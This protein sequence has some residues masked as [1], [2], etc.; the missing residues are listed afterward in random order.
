MRRS[1]CEDVDRQQLRLDG[2]VEI[3][4]PS[5]NTDVLPLQ[6]LTKLADGLEQIEDLW[7]DDVSEGEEGSDIDVD[8]DV[9]VWEMDGEGQ[10]VGVE[11]EE[12]NG[13]WS[14]DEGEDEAGMD[15]D[16]EDGWSSSDPTIHHSQDHELPLA[17]PSDVAPASPVKKSS[18]P[19]ASTRPKSPDVPQDATEMD[20]TETEAV[21]DGE[22]PWKR[23]EV[24][25]SAPADHA[26][27]SS[28]PA[29]MSRGFMARLSREYRALQSSLPGN[30]IM[31]V[32]PSQ[33]ADCSFRLNSG[34]SI[35]GSNGPP[36]MSHHRP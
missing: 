31:A 7:G 14:T 6:R 33:K 30:D 29:P 24:L 13:D 17:V 16:D 23:F 5:G 27:Y 1:D 35:R 28:P 34:Q 3:V 4:L 8:G 12:D 15:V 20:D 32:D 21:E 22:S 10:W 25:P 26:F 9:E 11:G 2:T 19:P 36:S 18:D